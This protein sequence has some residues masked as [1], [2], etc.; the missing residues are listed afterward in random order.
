MQKQ[1]VKVKQKENSRRQQ[2]TEN[3]KE[4]CIHEEDNCETCENDFANRPPLKLF[5][6]SRMS[7]KCL[8]IHMHTYMYI[9]V[10]MIVYVCA[11]VCVLPSQGGVKISACKVISTPPPTP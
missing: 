2:L 3:S 10:V 9:N 1:K 8:K 6:K 5:Q 4:R 7:Q 11:C